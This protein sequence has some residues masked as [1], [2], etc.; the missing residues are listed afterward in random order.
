M[1]AASW[2]I[3]SLALPCEAPNEASGAYHFEDG[4]FMAALV[5][6]NLS[7]AGICVGCA[8]ARQI[9]VVA[10]NIFPVS[11]ACTHNTINDPP[12]SPVPAYATPKS[13]DLL[14]FSVAWLRRRLLP[15]PTPSVPLQEIPVG[16]E[17]RP[18]P[19]WWRVGCRLKVREGEGGAWR[20]GAASFT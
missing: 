19:A 4:E 7:R 12:R 6:G 8:C 17:G 1:L 9:D 5:E 14:R 2:S 10:D 18:T 3:N 13:I 20:A 11:T 16:V 15:M